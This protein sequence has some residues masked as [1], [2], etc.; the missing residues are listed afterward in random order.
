MK[1]FSPQGEKVTQP[2]ILHKNMLDKKVE[3]DSYDQY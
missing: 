2:I 3:V 1:I